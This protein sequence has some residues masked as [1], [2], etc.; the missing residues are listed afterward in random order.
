MQGE[1]SPFVRAAWQ[2]EI[3]EIGDA[4]REAEERKRTFWWIMAILAATIFEGA[5]RKWLLAP[6]YRP[7]AYVAKDVI[8]ICFMFTHPIPRRFRSVCR[9]RVLFAAV[10]VVLLF[11]L[12]KGLGEAPS[13]AILKYKN[14]VVWPLVGLHIAAWVDGQ[15]LARIA[16]VLVP[17]SVAM[18][19][20][21]VLQYESAPSAFVNHYAWSTLESSDAAITFGGAAGVRATGTFSFIAGMSTYAVVVF[22]FLLWRLL[23][24]PDPREKN[25]AIVGMVAAVVCGL[26]TGSRIV[27]VSAG[28][29][30]ALT[31]VASRNFRT[32]IRL[33]LVAVVGGAFLWLTASS[34][35]FGAF[36]GRWQTAGDNLTDRI[37]GV[38]LA[39]DYRQL[40]SDS[41]FGGGLGSAT[42]LAHQ[43]GGGAAGFDHPI[44]NLVVEGGFLGIMGL[45]LTVLGALSLLGDGLTS[46]STNFRLGTYAVALVALYTLVNLPWGDHV[47]A[48][49]NW[50][51]I[52]FWFSSH[53]GFQA[54]ATAALWDGDLRG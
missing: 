17:L 3:L 37:T 44:T 43:L 1:L 10:G 27:V 23:T 16:R 50:S 42:D 36:V 13:A 33:T 41:P 38:G 52:G 25:Y 22:N 48:A 18:A 24:A 14:A 12:I 19:L 45:G 7:I 8:A 40:L 34:G 35:F 39:G 4:Q 15:M 6:Q 21:G 9:T 30:T 29:A 5:L 32:L 49:L 26:T 20:L 54:D 2:Q 11:P 47:A 31:L 51:V 53:P 28:L 46:R